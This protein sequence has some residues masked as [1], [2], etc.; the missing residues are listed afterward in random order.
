MITASVFDGR[1]CTLG[2]GPIWH[3]QRQQLFWFDILSKKLLTRTPNGPADW[4]F[5]EHFSAAGWIDHDILLLASETGLWHFDINTGKEEKLV[6]LE[7]GN[8]ITRSNDGRADPF[9][10]FWIGTMGKNAEQEAGSIYRFYKGE[11]RTL[12]S[13]LTIPNSICF[14]PDGR[15]AYYAD[16][17]RSR[18]WAVDLDAEGWPKGETKLFLDLSPDDLNPDGSVVDAEGGMWN[19]Q[20]GAGRI[21]RYLPDGTL[22]RTVEIPAPHCSCPAFG[23][24][25]LDELF[26]ATA[27][28]GLNAKAR[29]ASPLSG[30]TFVIA[31]GVKGQAE[32]QVLL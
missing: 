30:Q 22:D 16:T 21:A 23:G 24:A 9:G 25:N 10:G 15:L 32:H 5:A 2:E 31:S 19:A 3:P 28:Q 13:D 12:V 18:I 11:I 20:W 27:T 7:A 29:A 6:D 14:S 4:Q 26:V 1:I 17:R 8:P